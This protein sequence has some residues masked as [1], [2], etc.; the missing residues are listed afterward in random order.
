[1]DMLYGA[2]QGDLSKTYDWCGQ[3]GCALGSNF[4]LIIGIVIGVVVL[5]IIVA[6]CIQ[7]S[8]KRAARA[9]QMY[10]MDGGSYQPIYK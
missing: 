5:I 2:S 8:R 3:A 1:M 7:Q 6:V 10:N 9:A 4:G